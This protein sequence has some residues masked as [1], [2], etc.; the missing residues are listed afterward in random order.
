MCLC[1]S[2]KPEL[3]VEIGPIIDPYGPSIVDPDL[4]A[5]IVSK[6]TLPGGLSVNKKRADRGLSQLQIEAVD[7]V[8]EGSGGA[9]LCS[10][11]LRKIEYDN[12][13]SKEPLE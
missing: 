11:A 2:I 1:Q 10:T 9:K 3:I 6:E 5:I 13:N 7:L 12:K 4:E 8:P